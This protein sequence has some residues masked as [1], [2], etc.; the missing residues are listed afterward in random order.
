[1]HCENISAGKPI[2]SRLEYQRP[3]D[4]AGLLAFFRGRALS[5]V[6]L[7]DDVSYMRSVR[8]ADR[9]GKACEGLFRVTDDEDSGSLLLEMSS[10]LEPVSEEIEKRVRYMF[11]LDCDPAAVEAAIAPLREAIPGIS[12]G[13]V[14]VPG[15]FEPFEIACRAVLG[16]QVSVQAANKFAERIVKEFGDEVRIEGFPEPSDGTCRY[17]NRVWPTPDRILA[18]EDIQG[19]FGSL[20]VIGNRSRVIAEIARMVEEGELELTPFAYSG[21]EPEGRVG[22][23]VMQMERLLAVKG[24]GP[25][26]ANYMAMRALGHPD[27]FL[28]KDVGV[29]HALP[30]MEPKE[31]LEAVEDCRPYRSYAVLALWNNVGSAAD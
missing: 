7:V 26:T 6:E 12:I 25:W 29:I 9:E 22:H 11:D 17:P 13:S 10:S 21:E 4:F 5:G 19:A 2:I 3:F 23:A 20:G 14:R 31:R 27:A 18:I 15:A 30:D 8:M 16:Q 28:E 24:I 1:M